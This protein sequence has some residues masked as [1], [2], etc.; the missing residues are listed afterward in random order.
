M[1]LR[2]RILLVDDDGQVLF[3]LQTALVKLG[4]EYEVVTARTG[5]EALA[6]VESESFDL[7]IT[8]LKMPGIGGAHLTEEIME[9]NPGAVVI[10]FTAFGSDS[11]RTQARALGVY[12]CL[13]KPVEVDALRQIV[14]EALTSAAR[15]QLSVAGR[16]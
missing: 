12:R 8:D 13:D 7:L 5:H 14:R 1:E 10:W 3:V 15:P 2:K 6:H 16:E 9:R 11:V 4:K